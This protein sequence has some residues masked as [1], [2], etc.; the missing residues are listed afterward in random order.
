MVYCNKGLANEGREQTAPTMHPHH[1]T[2]IK[3]FFT[4][5]LRGYQGEWTQQPTTLGRQQAAQRWSSRYWNRLKQKTASIVEMH[6][7]ACIIAFSS[8]NTLALFPE[9]SE[10]T[11]A[12]MRKQKVSE[13]SCLQCSSWKKLKKYENWKE[14]ALEKSFF[15]VLE[16]VSVFA[17]EYWSVYYR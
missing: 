10:E 15:Q 9:G 5:T 4:R 1:C 2:P 14:A 3:P 17:T 12:I 7:K 6:M 11:E 8:A 16:N 13:R